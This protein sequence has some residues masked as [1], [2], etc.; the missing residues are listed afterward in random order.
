V[1]VEP[2]GFLPAMQE[3]SVA[4]ERADG[5]DF[6]QWLQQRLS[7]TNAKLIESDRQIERVATGEADNLHHVMIALEDARLSFQLMVQVRNKLLDAY[8]D[9]LRMQ[10]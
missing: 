9:I 8:Q 1:N 6:S 5:A 7:E 2:A 10:I 3:I 4:A